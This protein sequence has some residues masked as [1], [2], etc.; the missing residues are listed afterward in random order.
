[1]ADISIENIDARLQRP[2]F[3]KEIQTFRANSPLAVSYTISMLKD[4]GVAESISTA[5]DKEYQ[6]TARAQEFGDFQEGIRAAVIDKDRNP[7]WKQKNIQEI[8]EK[9]L[10]IF[11]KPMPRNRRRK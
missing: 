4:R 11:Q 9:D 3:E 6:Y 1:M 2:I 7:R 8:T 10:E 5:L